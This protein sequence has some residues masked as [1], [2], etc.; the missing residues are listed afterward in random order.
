MIDC[1][2]VPAEEETGKGLRMLFHLA[3]GSV[4]VLVGED[5]EKRSEDLVLHD[6]VVP[7]HWVDNRGIEIAC[8]R[9]RGPAYD[10]FLLIDQSCQT[11][12]RLGANDSGVVVR[13]ALRVGPVQL[14][15]RLLALSNKLLRNRFVH[16]GISGRSAPLAAP[17]RSP[18]D[19]LFGC[20]R[21]IGGRINKGWVLAPEF[22]KNRSQVF[23][24]RFHHD[25]ANLDAA[26][27]ENEVEGQLEQFRHL[28]LTSRDGSNGPRIEMFWNEI[29]QDLT[30]GGQT[31]G[32]FED[33]WIASR[34]N[35]DSGVEEQ[36]QWS[37]EWPDNQGDAVRFPIDFSSMPA[38]PK[39]LGHNHIY[40]LHPLLQF[41]LREG[42][43]AYRRHSLEDFF[44][45]GRL[46]VAAHRSLKSLGVLITQ[47]L[48]ACQLINAP[49]VRLGRVRIEI[50]FLLVEDFLELIHLSLLRIALSMP[51]CSSVMSS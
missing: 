51:L 45:A 40:G 6:R 22:E 28:V 5:W 46:E 12:S 37:V 2:L 26:G 3:N 20:V 24:G 25:L 35:L 9:V 18:P 14:D 44:L 36:R 27:E 19:N 4:H 8:I 23:C 34:N 42:D 17:S 50:C 47:V 33:A 1:L 10:D 29:E 13:S 43:G 49:L 7:C 48:K 39:G 16:V 41:L 15:H 21:D 11:F 31:L 32:E 30:G 38:L